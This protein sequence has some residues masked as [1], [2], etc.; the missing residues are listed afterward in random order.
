MTISSGWLLVGA[1]ALALL[2]VSWLLVHGNRCWL[3]VCSCMVDSRWWMVFGC[4]LVLSGSCWLIVGS[5]MVNCRW[6][7]V[8]GS[9]LLVDPWWQLLVDC[10]FL[11][12]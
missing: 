10:W 1:F 6:P 12:G 2:V 11:H 5:C 8:V 7:L 9:Q 3:N 4:L